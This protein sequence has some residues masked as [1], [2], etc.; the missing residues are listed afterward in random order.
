[1]RKIEEINAEYQKLCTVL[2]DVEV[3]KQG[4]ENQRTAIFDRL[5]QLDEEARNLQE[6]QKNED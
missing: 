4:L 1:M 2:G 5:N 3:K 6:G